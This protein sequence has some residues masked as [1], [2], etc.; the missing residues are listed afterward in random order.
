M[1]VLVFGPW[2]NGEEEG[3]EC[4]LVEECF[5]N[6]NTNIK[7][8]DPLKEKENNAKKF[9]N[10]FWHRFFKKLLKHR[11][12]SSSLRGVTLQTKSTFSQSS[13]SSDGICDSLHP[14]IRSRI[15]EL[16]LGIDDFT[17]AP[18]HVSKEIVD[19]E[20]LK[21]NGETKNE[22][23]VLKNE[24]GVIH[25]K[26]G[27]WQITC[28]EDDGAPLEP[29]YAVTAVS[30]KDRVDTKKLRKALFSG[31]TMN[32]RPKIT[33]APKEIA[34][35]LTGFQSGT[36][37]PIC[38]LVNSMLF[39]EESIVAHEQECDDCHKRINVGSGMFGTCLSL[40]M[41]DFIRI[42]KVNPEGMRVCPLI[43]RRGGVK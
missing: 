31:S 24:N 18:D 34:E 10:F 35:K 30:M 22:D 3:L 32:R 33:M 21:E 20:M 12:S 38:H 19:I 43:Q 29:F 23:H 36:M 26:T 27:V 4:L 28:L 25:V 7:H 5:N 14:P 40:P 9:R 42:A 41:R 11:A 13:L 16:D 37:A 15:L 17:F 8:K 39:V 1:D 2:S 6:T